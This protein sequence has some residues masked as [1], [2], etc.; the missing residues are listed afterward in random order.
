MMKQLY[1]KDWGLLTGAAWGL[2]QMTVTKRKETERQAHHFT[3]TTEN[4]IP[5]TATPANSASFYLWLYNFFDED[6]S[7]ASHDT[8]FISPTENGEFD[9]IHLELPRDLR[10]QRK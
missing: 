1:P 5:N 10:A 9:T 8:V 6:P 7:M 3:I 4:D 2:N